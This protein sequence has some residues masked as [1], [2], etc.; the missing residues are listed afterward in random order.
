MKEQNYPVAYACYCLDNNARIQSSSGGI[1]YALSKQ[2]IDAGG[3]VF[4]AAFDTNWYV[5]HRFVESLDE[6]KSLMGSKYIQSDI[7]YSYIQVKNFLK[8]GRLVLFCGTPCQISGLRSYLGKDYENLILV[9]FVCHGVASP[10]VWK[11]YLE[12]IS[13][14]REIC[15]ISFRDKSKG[16]KKFMLRITFC[17]GTKYEENPHVDPFMKA[18]LNDIIQ[19]PACYKCQF[20]GIIRE[21]DITL[22]DFWGIENVLPQMFDDNGISLMLVNTVKANALI[23]SASGGIVTQNVCIDDVLKYNKNI[24]CSIIEPSRR[25]RFFSGMDQSVAEKLSIFTRDPIVKRVKNAIKGLVRII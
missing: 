3:V 25:K 19:R 8:Q 12:E 4:G 14:G 22:G 5:A 20:K 23:E 15:D 2:V 11:D 10:K 21:S 18:F 24:C 17:D 9:D 16:W 7:G 6:L 13:K 1:F